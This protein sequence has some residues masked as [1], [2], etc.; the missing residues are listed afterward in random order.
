MLELKVVTVHLV[1]CQCRSSAQKYQVQLPVIPLKINLV[2]SLKACKILQ[3]AQPKLIRL[4]K[5]KLQQ[6][7]ISRTQ[8]SR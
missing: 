1:T 7:L 3:L 2:Y 6:Q 8:S 5:K 4:A